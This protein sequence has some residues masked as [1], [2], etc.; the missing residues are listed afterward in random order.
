[1]D[2][3][4]V[5]VYRGMRRQ[6]GQLL[7]E[8]HGEVVRVLRRRRPTLVGR[9]VPDPVRPWVDP[10]ARRLNMRVVL[11]PVPEEL[12]RPGEFVEVS[13]GEIPEQGPVQGRL[14]RR[15]GAP[16]EGALTRRSCSPSWQFPW[17]SHRARCATRMACPPTSCP[18]TLRAE[19]T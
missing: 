15:L 13:V 7:P 17:S 1:M 16:G 5:L 18:G 19:R 4:Q 12:P 14:L 11:D 8:K 9:F 10:Y 3:A 2:G 6:R